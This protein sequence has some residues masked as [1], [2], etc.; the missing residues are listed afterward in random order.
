MDK[1]GAAEASAPAGIARR[2]GEYLSLSGGFDFCHQRFAKQDGGSPNG[3]TRRCLPGVS[4]KVPSLPGNLEAVVPEFISAVPVARYGLPG[5]TF[6]YHYIQNGT[7]DDGPSLSY[8]RRRCLVKY[9]IESHGWVDHSFSGNDLNI[10]HCG[11]LG[12][13]EV[14]QSITQ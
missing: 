9:D 12:R 4:R 3:E 5:D 8:D 7:F 2:R 10:V 1:L 11:E 6:Q 13:N 14:H